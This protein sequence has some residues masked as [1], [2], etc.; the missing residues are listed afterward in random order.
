MRKH[1]HNSEKSRTFAKEN[2]KGGKR[3]PDVVVRRVNLKSNS[4]HLNFNYYD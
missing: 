2:I 1:L 4:K 3:A